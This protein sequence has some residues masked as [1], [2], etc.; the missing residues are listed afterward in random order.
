M[1][2]Y[3]LWNNI[4]AWVA[5]VIA[6]FTYLSTIEPTA[7]FWDCGEF[8]ATADKLL[9]GH[10]PGAPFFMIMGRFFAL[11]A[12]SQDKVAM[13][14]NAMSALSSAF[15]ILFLY[16]TI[17]HLARKI[18]VGNN[19]ADLSKTQAFSVL[20]AGLIG[21]LAYTF[22]DTFWFSAVEGEVYAMSSLFTAAVFWAI[23]KWD[24]EA[25][26]PH[27]MRWIILIGFLIGLSIGVHLLNL[28]AIP[29]IALVFYYR[30]HDKPTPKGLIITLA[31]SFVLLMFIMYGIVPGTVRL[32][33]LF[34]LMFVNGFGLPFNSGMV[35]FYIAL[36]AALV[37][38]IHYTYK[39]GHVNVN[40]GL[41]FLTVILIGYSAFAMILIRANAEPPMNQND[42]KDAFSLYS[43]LNREQ[44]GNRPLVYGQYYNAPVVGSKSAGKIR[45]QIDGKY[46][47]VD[48]RPEYIYD[49]RFETLFPR[50]YSDQ[51]QHIREYK[52]WA[53]IKGTKIKT[54]DGVLV[55]PT[56]GENIRFFVKYQLNFMYWRYFM[57]NF[58]G[59]QNDQQ[60]HGSVLKGNWISGIHFLDDL[61]LGGDSSKLPDSIKNDKSRNTYYML[62]LLLGI[63][64]IVFQLKRK[65]KRG[66]ESFFIVTAL[67]VLT[68]VAIVVYLN[69]YPLQPRERDYAYAA[70]F[71]AFCIWIGLGVLYL[72]ELIG[73]AI[74]SEYSA[75]A[76]TAIALVVPGIL[77]AENWDDHDR[78]DRYMCRDFANN[79]LQSCA[80]NA[81]IFTN[82]DN[83]TFP[84]W[85][86]QEVEGI[87]TD[88]RV[89]NLSYLQT[90]WYID[91]MRKDAYDSEGLPFSLNKEQTRQGRIGV[92]HLIDRTG[93]KPFDLRNA[94]KWLASDRKETKEIPGYGN[95]E[96]FPA[97]KFYLPVNK[98]KVIAEGVVAPEDSASIVDQLN[99]DYSKENYIRKNKLMM[100]DLIQ[101]ADW[102]RP[103][104][105]AVT[106]PSE[107]HIGLRNHFEVTGQAYRIVPRNTK[108]NGLYPM[109]GIGEINT[110]VMYDNMMNKYRYGGIKTPGVYMEENTLRMSKNYRLNFIRLASALYNEGKIDKAKAAIERCFEEIPSYNVPYSAIE[111]T[112]VDILVKLDMN[113][114]ALEVMKEMHENAYQD[115]QYYLTF[116]TKHR[117]HVSEA[118]RNNLMIYQNIIIKYAQKLDPEL[119][120][121]A[122]KEFQEFYPKA[123]QLIS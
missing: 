110:D 69:Q 63:L 98:E 10:P 99:F 102:E 1:S 53:K 67:F 52:K 2:N 104:Y 34:E 109:L 39:K 103:I 19:A 121:Q 93:G 65:N 27:A 16:W 31:I 58:A 26:Q 56:Y 7:S 78:S 111:Y 108:D 61:R 113:D 25:D 44:Y 86:A 80:P 117:S 72:T 20:G 6:A 71:Y 70:S 60:S 3:K 4:L 90:D 51:S 30:R 41:T 64:G 95:I 46:Q 82:G 89:C 106:V 47:V 123:T 29:A 87:R 40:T 59:R 28:L 9:V 5:F 107:Y 92:A 105:I 54:D 112:L 83:D 75:V 8:I 33:S 96:H 118:V 55:K 68:G 114:K 11:F 22:T 85:Y 12:P 74:K 23:L 14:I 122:I 76:A 57:W 32:A 18:L 115:M 13:M 37:Y 116:D 15:T 48:E 38:G 49:E 24:E 36:A 101:T 88:V 42:P 35:F 73:K 84:L 79:Y 50:M 120:E 100:L 43:Y 81:I 77:A 21:A 45:A 97:K 94:F 17:T 91:Q 62:P 119:Y 66:Y